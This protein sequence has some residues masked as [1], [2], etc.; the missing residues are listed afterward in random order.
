M[1]PACDAQT[2]RIT[3]KILKSIGASFLVLAPAVPASA[4]DSGPGYVQILSV[5]QQGA[6]IFAISGSS[7]G[8]WLACASGLQRYAISTTTA[9]GQG[10]YT[11]ILTA[12]KTHTQITV[13]GKANC[14]VWGDSESVE[15]LSA[16][17]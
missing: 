15:Y 4:T 6:P 2:G 9:A 17:S 11:L 5:L 13:H 8:S 3:M 14:D 10:M 1:D 16:T 7:T 12:L